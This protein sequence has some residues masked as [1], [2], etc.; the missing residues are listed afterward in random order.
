MSFDSLAYLPDD[1][2]VIESNDD[3]DGICEDIA[4]L[5][6]VTHL[7]DD[8]DTLELI[9]GSS[10]PPSNTY[11]GPG[12]FFDKEIPSLFSEMEY[13]TE[14]LPET[15]SAIEPC[16]SIPLAVNPTEFSWKRKEQETEQESLLKQIKENELLPVEMDPILASNGNTRYLATTNYKKM[17]NSYIQKGKRKL[18]QNSYSKMK[19]T[20]VSVATGIN[21]T[22]LVETVTC[23][24]LSDVPNPTATGINQRTDSYV[25]TEPAASMPNYRCQDCN[26]CFVSVERLKKHPCIIAEQYQCQLCRREFRKQKTLEQHFKSHDKVFSTDEDLRKF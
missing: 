1:S 25:Q 9:P 8:L 11:Y 20:I 7:V 3:F 18:E 12:R 23:A 22:S 2:F 13:L 19:A 4:R 5:A 14:V 15:E 17:L 24:S 26:T 6:N 10:S 16:S 21:S